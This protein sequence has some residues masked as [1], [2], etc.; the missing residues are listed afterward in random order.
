MRP[1]VPGLDQPR[2][3]TI[4]SLDEAI[5]LRRLL[6]TGVVR[7]AIVVGAGYIGLETAEALVSAG[8]EVQVIEALPRVLGTVDE[9][10][11]DLAGAELKR[12]ARL[13]LGA[14][15]DAVQRPGAGGPDRGRGR[16]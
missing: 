15:L 16:R 12:H 7:R 8:I 13:R 5:E 9:P 4:R 1:P 6:D 14:R 3:F 2:V 11:A 10:I